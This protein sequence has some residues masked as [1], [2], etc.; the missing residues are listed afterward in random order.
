M[1]GTTH[2]VSRDHELTSD[3]AHLLIA[4]LLVTLAIALD[5]GL[6]IKLVGVGEQVGDL[7]EFDPDA[8]VDAL[9]TQ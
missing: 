4:E 5:L 3:S 1:D 9:V 6:P 7:I 8:F 2:P